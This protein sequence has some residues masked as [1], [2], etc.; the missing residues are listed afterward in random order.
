MSALVLAQSAGE[1]IV[2]MF[3]AIGAN[4]WLDYRESQPNWIQV[5][6]GACPEH[7]PNLRLLFELTR[8]THM[9]SLDVLNLVM[10]RKEAVLQES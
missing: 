10:P 7:E 4:A 2:A 6:V 3:E 8:Y 5:K 9:I 1:R